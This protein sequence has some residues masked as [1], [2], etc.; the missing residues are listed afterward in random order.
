MH[1]LRPCF[2][3]WGHGGGVGCLAGTKLTSREKCRAESKGWRLSLVRIT[4]HRTGKGLGKG[5]PREHGGGGG[6]G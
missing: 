2:Q 4:G 5:I 1:W 3:G 6:V